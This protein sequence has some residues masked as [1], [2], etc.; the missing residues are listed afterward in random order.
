MATDIELQFCNKCLD[1]HEERIRNIE[2]NN[3]L[4]LRVEILEKY[5][6]GQLAVVKTEKEGRYDILSILAILISLSTMIMIVLSFI[7]K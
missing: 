5:M 7:F 3:K 1:D 4:E 2:K 6:T